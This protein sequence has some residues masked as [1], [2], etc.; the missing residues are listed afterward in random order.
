MCAYIV[1]ILFKHFTVNEQNNNLCYDSM[2]CRCLY[3][4]A[5]PGF[6]KEGCECWSGLWADIVL[7]CIA[8]F[9]SVYDCHLC[10]ALETNLVKAKATAPGSATVYG[11]LCD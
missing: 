6:F 5:D 2:N 9:N 3:A 11:H 1:V 7:H 4:V 10:E 8:F